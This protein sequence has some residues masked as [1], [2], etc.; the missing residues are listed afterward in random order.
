MRTEGVDMA[1]ESRSAPVTG[2]IAD[3]VQA[4]PAVDQLVA[5]FARM[6]GFF[7][8]AGTAGT[9]LKLITHAGRQRRADDRGRHR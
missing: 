6:S 1:P 7:L 8:T 5:A 9:A 4:Q 3:A 2:T